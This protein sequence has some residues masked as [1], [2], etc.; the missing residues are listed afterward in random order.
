MENN[1][2][3]VV[4]PP[5]ADLFA[6]AAAAIIDGVVGGVLVS[7]PLVGFLASAAYLLLKDGLIYQINGQE[8][9]KNRSIGK[10][11]MKLEV[12]YFEGDL[13]DLT[14]S[15]RRNIPLAIGSIIG[16]IPVLGWVIGPIIGMIMAIIELVMVL[17]DESG[18]RLGDN[19][20]GTQV[21]MSSDI[22]EE[23]G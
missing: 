20:A 16:I 4:E 6:R 13:V 7:V 10:K 19:W 5:K 15:A 21:V 3:K 9:W 8:E 11:V 2:V 22:S 14:V 18:R 17:T 1:E 12:L 23:Q